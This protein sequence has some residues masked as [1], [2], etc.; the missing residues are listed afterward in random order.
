MLTLSY[1]LSGLLALPQPPLLS[2]YLVLQQVCVWKYR[3]QDVKLFILCHHRRTQVCDVLIN[4]RK[5]KTS[6]VDFNNE[7]GKNKTKPN[8]GHKQT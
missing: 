4:I 1:F 8:V 3:G 5:T 6:K 7:T 2:P